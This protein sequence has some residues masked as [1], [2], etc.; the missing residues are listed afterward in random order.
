MAPVVVDVFDLEP[1][2]S[3]LRRRRWHALEEIIVEQ[4]L[5]T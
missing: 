4:G 3:E 2:V 5:P 1:T